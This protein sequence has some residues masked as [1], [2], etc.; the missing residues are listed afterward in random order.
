MKETRKPAPTE[1]SPVAEVLLSSRK[2]SG[3]SL[4]KMNRSSITQLGKAPEPAQASA[5]AMGVRD[6]SVEESAA[7]VGR[8]RRKVIDRFAGPGPVFDLLLLK[9]KKLRLTLDLWNQQLRLELKH[10]LG[11]FSAIKWKRLNT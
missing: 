5:A 9:K 10:F 2:D 4:R 3:S 7:T 8:G 1:V 6:G 11:L